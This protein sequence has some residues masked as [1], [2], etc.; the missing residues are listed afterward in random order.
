MASVIVRRKQIYFIISA[1]IIYFGLMFPLFVALGHKPATIYYQQLRLDVL[2]IFFILGVNII[3]LVIFSFAYKLHIPREIKLKNENSWIL[4]L[5]CFTI[6]I[7]LN[8]DAYGQDRSYIKGNS[9]AL[10]VLLNSAIISYYSATCITTVSKPKFFFSVGVLL[11]V[12]FL[13][14]EREIILALF[15]ALILRIR[16]T[17]LLTIKVAMLGVISIIALAGSKYI[18]AYIRLGQKDLL[19][20]IFDQAFF[21]YVISSLMRDN[22]HKGYLEFAYFSGWSPDYHFLTYFMPLQLHREI[23]SGA[24]TNGQMATDFYTMAETGTGFSIIIEAWQNFG[25]LGVFVIPLVIVVLL[26]FVASLGSAFLVVSYLLFV[27]K[28]QRAELWPTFIGY[29]LGP[30]VVIIIYISIRKLVFHLKSVS[31]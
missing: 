26:R 10:K 11:G 28:L 25:Y 13:M 5:F 3:Y 8:F 2:L 4:L 19:S 21:N 16:E 14:Q 27:F 17:K 24:Q 15:V 12:T 20:I 9:N 22:L 23:V 31:L 29:L 6:F 30:L 1:A 7:I 18:L